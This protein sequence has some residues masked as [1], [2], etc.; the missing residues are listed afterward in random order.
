MTGSTRARR[1]GSAVVAAAPAVLAVAVGLVLAGADPARADLVVLTDGA[2]LKVQS[3]QMKGDNVEM[4]L[5]SGGKLTLSIERI[6]R[7]IADEV[8]A[9]EAELAKPAPPPP[10]FSLRFV[11]GQDRPD[12]PYGDPIYE[13]ARRNGLNPSLVAA[14]VA[15]ESRFNAR[16]V[17]HAGARGLMQL[18]P[19]TGRRMGVSPSELFEPEKNLEAGAHYL[20][21]LL[22]R[23][24]GELDLALSAYNA[25]EGAVD[26]HGGVP[27]YVETRAYI[28]KVYD[29]LGADSGL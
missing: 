24:Q 19:A 20:R 16:A 8:V 27:P 9:R 11:E 5:D 13:A 2:Y 25:G 21:E 3:Y 4:V 26:R 1:R 14:V 23:Y 28:R 15:A 12:T 22:D 29:V 18:M 17:S 6:D 7:V 10:A